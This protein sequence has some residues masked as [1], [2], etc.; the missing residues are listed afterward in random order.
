MGRFLILMGLCFEQDSLFHLLERKLKR[1]KNQQI[2]AYQEP[3]DDVLRQHF[4]VQ[5][6]TFW[7]LPG[8][9]IKKSNQSENT[10]HSYDGECQPKHLNCNI[11]ESRP[12]PPSFRPNNQYIAASIYIG[13]NGSAACLW[14]AVVNSDS[15]WVTELRQNPNSLLTLLCCGGLAGLWYFLEA[16]PKQ[17]WSNKGLIGWRLIRKTFSVVALI[18]RRRH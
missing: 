13:T 6:M 9:D 7:N 5:I 12:S 17:A 18:I 4:Q 16:Y 15:L 11:L 8:D 3:S 1:N 10:S 14:W 2:F